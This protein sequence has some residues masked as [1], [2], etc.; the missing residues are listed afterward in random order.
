MV[1]LEL[2]DNYDP[3]ADDIG[4]WRDA[5]SEIRGRLIVKRLRDDTPHDVARAIL[6]LIGLGYDVV[7]PASALKEHGQ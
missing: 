7:P 1:M 6:R 3:H 2:H 5:V 4:S